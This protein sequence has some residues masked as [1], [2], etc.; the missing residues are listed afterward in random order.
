MESDL[1]AN[2]EKDV[3]SSQPDCEEVSVKEQEGLS[4]M[5]QRLG[6]RSSSSEDVALQRDGCSYYTTWTV[7]I[8]LAVP[9]EEEAA[10]PTKT[11]K[12]ERK[13]SSAVSV[14]A[15][16]A[17]SCYHIEYKLLP[18]DTET[19]KLDLVVFGPGAKLYKDDESKILITW[20]EGDQI[21]VSWSHSFNIRVNRDALISLLPYK[22]PVKIWNAMYRLSSFQAR[23]E[24]QKLFR[25]PKGWPEDASDTCDDIK[26]MVSQLTPKKKIGDIWLD[27]NLDVGL[28]KEKKSALQATPSFQKHNTDACDLGEMGNSGATSVEVSPLR[29]LAGETSVTERFQV[30]SSGLCEVMC[31]ISLDGP[32]L[33]NQLKAELN[34]MVITILS[35]TSMPS[36]PVPL[37]VLQ[38]K[39]MPVYCQYK[40]HNLSMHRTNYHKHETNIY[41]RDVNVILTGLMNPQELQDFFATPSLQIEVH[42]RDR[43]VEERPKPVTCDT[44]SDDDMHSNASLFDHNFH[45]Y[46]IANLNLSEL[47]LG[48]KSLKVDLPIKCGPLPPKLDRKRSRR[49][50][51]MTDTAASRD[52]MPQADYYDVNSQLKVKVEM[53][54]PLTTDDGMEFYSGPFSRIVYLFDYNNFSVIIKLRSEILRINASA[55]HLDSL[56]LESRG[57]ALSNKEG[58]M[59]LKHDESTD[60]DFVTGFHVQDKRKHILVLEGLKHKAVR[61]LWEAVPMKLSGTEAEQVIVLYNSNLCFFKRIYDSLDV[62]LS[63]IQLRESLQSI[64]IQPLIYIRGKLP[65][66]CFQAL[67]RLSQLCQVRH[68]KDAVQYDLFPSAD[69][70]VSMSREYGTSAE[71]WEQQAS[72]YTMMD[73]PTHPVR[74]KTHAA[75]DACN[76]EYIR[77]KHNRQQTPAEPSRDFI[78]ENIQSV[79]DQSEQLQKPQAAALTLDLAATMPVHNYSIQTFNSN[80]QARELLLR[81][82]AKVP[83]RRFTYSLGY[84]SATVETGDTTPKNDSGSAAA[85]TAWL[86]NL[87]GDR[88]RVHP[89]HPDEARVEELRKPWIENI[90]HANTLKPILSR[91]RWVWS[92]RH[93]D[94]QL[95]SKPPAVVPLEI[96]HRGGKMG[97]LKILGQQKP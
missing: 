35:A 62:S 92:Q 21:W 14:K 12:T 33:S 63:P 3:C 28:E 30:C 85:S 40:F 83:G 25:F 73:L 93:E 65:Q 15:H 51:K 82:L 6:N 48:K 94:F 17:Q 9:R 50:S 67:S 32:L 46:G 64:M 2:M 26:T 7:N 71:Q 89:R 75:L 39:C 76:R 77:W 11:K 42:D 52:P 78:Q 34:P 41:F 44:E 72:A 8:A 16:K 61:R 5:D 29:F 53:A 38:E 49:N 23:S 69:M 18:G 66:P 47:L 68:L 22:I 10:V 80:V 45:T 74:M 81:E 31:S 58:P 4:S 79:Q 57:R 54:C 97:P 24:S 70:I 88:S 90:L 27:S 84:H 20:Y 19:T 86:T 36:S 55:F 43:K 96:F 91:D 95:Y 56:S 1:M 13:C 37:H 87:S 60:L 59:N